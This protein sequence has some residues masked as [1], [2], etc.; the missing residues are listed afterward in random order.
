MSYIYSLGQGFRRLQNLHCNGFVLEQAGTD[1]RTN[2]ILWRVRSLKPDAVAEPSRSGIRFLDLLHRAGWWADAHQHNRIPDSR[3]LCK[4]TVGHL[5]VLSSQI[6]SLPEIPTTDSPGR[7]EKL[8]AWAQHM[9]IALSSSTPTPEAVRDQSEA[10][11]ACLLAL[12][13][14][15][16]PH[17]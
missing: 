15:G 12:P 6:L 17:A 7:V 16:A 9:V 4:Q 2:V 11:L 3:C 5:R 13:Q 14:E 1:P 10:I 8:R